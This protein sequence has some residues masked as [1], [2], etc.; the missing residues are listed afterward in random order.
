MPEPGLWI[1]LCSWQKDAAIAGRKK[2]ICAD[3]EEAIRPL[4]LGITR[5]HRQEKRRK[6]AVYVQ[7]RHQ[8]QQTACPR[9]AGPKV[10]TKTE[11][12]LSASRV[13]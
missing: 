3:N 7:R 13:G 11:S 9:I 5:K 1:G 6:D 2:Q 10:L 8:K 12:N 4:L